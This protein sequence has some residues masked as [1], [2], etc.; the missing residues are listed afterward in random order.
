MM[1]F[2]FVYIERERGFFFLEFVFPFLV[3]F[4]IYKFDLFLLDELLLD[5]VKVNIYGKSFYFFIFHNCFYFIFDMISWIF[6][7]RLQLL[8]LHK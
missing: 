1:S 7:K 5:I 4:Y 2:L 6:L 8:T 3:F